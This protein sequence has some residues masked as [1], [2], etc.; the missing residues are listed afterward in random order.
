[1]RGYARVDEMKSLPGHDKRKASP[2]ATALEQRGGE[3]A[4]SWAEAVRREMPESRFATLPWDELLSWALAANQALI[5]RLRT[6]PEASRPAESL[7]L[8]QLFSSAGLE[9]G[10]VAR[11]VLLGQG[12]VA[13]MLPPSSGLASEPVVPIPTDEGFVLRD[14]LAGFLIAFAAETRRRDQSERERTATLLRVATSCGS[15]LDLSEVLRRTSSVLSAAMGASRCW[16]Y[17]FHHSDPKLGTWIEPDGPDSIDPVPDATLTRHFIDRAAAQAGPVILPG[18][19]GEPEPKGELESEW[20]QSPQPNSIMVVPLVSE[21]TNLGLVVAVSL[22]G[23]R[24]FSPEQ[25]EIAKGIASVVTPAIANAKLFKKVERLAL[26]EERARL[27]RELHDYIAQA[28]ACLA[29]RI[30]IVREM[31]SLGEADRAKAILSEVAQITE[32]AYVDLREAIFCLRAAV[33][34]GPGFWPALRGYLEEYEAS[35]GMEVCLTTEGEDTTGFPP[36]TSVQ[37]SRI[38]LEALAN[39]R[40]HSGATVVSVKFARFDGHARITI[41]DNGQGFDSSRLSGVASQGVGLRVMQERA[42]SIGGTLEIGSR[43]GLGTLVALC[44]PLP[45]E[46]RP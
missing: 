21:G 39:T 42:E 40:K 19:S 1:L 6:Q 17:L 13:S 11:S 9:L 37:I 28:L 15:T 34:A 7:G 46:Q 22:E 4:L 5:R 45:Q 23:G 8:A 27:S 12:I 20:F 32:E 43:P 30:D 25:A 38:I 24:S 2:L 14:F 26:M 41:E 31:V 3:M 36:D 33:H 44:V 16:F 18:I 10:E 35:Y 29:T